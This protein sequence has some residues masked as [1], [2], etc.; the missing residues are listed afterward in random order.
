M[1]KRLAVAKK[2][3]GIS[4]LGG[5]QNLTGQSWEQPAVSGDYFEQEG[6]NRKTHIRVM[7]KRKN[8]DCT[9]SSVAVEGSTYQFKSKSRRTVK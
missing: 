5:I 6:S 1:V 4:I 3:C 7:E 2:S 9:G 8:W